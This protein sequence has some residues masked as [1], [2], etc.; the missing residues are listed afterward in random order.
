[1]N[2]TVKNNGSFGEVLQ[3]RCEQGDFLIT[4]PIAKG[5]TA[6][7]KADEK[8]FSSITGAPEKTKA[9]ASVNYLLDYLKIPSNKRSFRITL[10]CE[11]PVGSG[12]ASSTADCVAAMR[13]VCKYLGVSSDPELFSDIIAQ[14]E[15]HDGIMYP[16]CVI[17]NH[18][19][20]KLIKDLAFTPSCLVV[21][22][23]LKHPVSTIQ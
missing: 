1:M 6:T 14:I 5:T 16:N 9:T 17:Y 12:L 3:G 15:P 11:L 4:L 8:I 18:R 23:E 20:G 19:S 21:T 2:I 22:A 10:D 13:A 7:I